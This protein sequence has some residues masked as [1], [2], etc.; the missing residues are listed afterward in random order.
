MAADAKLA[1]LPKET[2]EAPAAR[3]AAPPQQPER[4][5]ALAAPPAKAMGRPR[6]RRQQDLAS[7]NVASQ[8]TFDTGYLVQRGLGARMGDEPGRPVQS[9]ADR[10]GRLAAGSSTNHRACY[11]DVCGLSPIRSPSQ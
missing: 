9:A 2:A 4:P 1:L 5:A 7:K 8:Q 6:R 10:A 11:H 3:R